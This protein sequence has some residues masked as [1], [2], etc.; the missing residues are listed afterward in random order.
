MLWPVVKSVLHAGPKYNIWIYDNI[1]LCN[2]RYQCWNEF[3]KDPVSLSWNVG[4]SS[5]KTRFHF[6][7]MTS[8]LSANIFLWQKVVD[9]YNLSF[10]LVFITFN[11]S[12]TGEVTELSKA[13][14]MSGQNVC[15]RLRK[16]KTKI[17]FFMIIY[18]ALKL[19][20]ASFRESE[21]WS[22]RK[23]ESVFLFF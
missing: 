22:V 14:V 13:M 6:H 12:T 4:T 18:V 15:S 16:S 19:K 2:E 5:E 10:A 9:I 21:S 8:F 3:R 20:M 11:H 1:F 17:K 23:R 7:E